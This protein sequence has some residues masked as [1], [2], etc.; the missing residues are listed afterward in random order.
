MECQVKL[1]M[2]LVN[3]VLRSTATEQITKYGVQDDSRG[4]H[5]TDFCNQVRIR[6]NSDKIQ[7]HNPD[8]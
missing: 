6:I 2:A 7:K 4:I 1:Q 5:G 8:V 3:L